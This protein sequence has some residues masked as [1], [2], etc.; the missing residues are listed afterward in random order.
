[1]IARAALSGRADLGSRDGSTVRACEAA[2]RESVRRVRWSDTGH[3]DLV[4][5]GEIVLADEPARCDSL[6]L[7]WR[8]GEALSATPPPMAPSQPRLVQALEQVIVADLLRTWRVGDVA[9]RLGT[10]TRRLQRQLQRSGSS[11][12]ELVHGVRIA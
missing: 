3:H 5:D 9:T 7:E 1:M 12:S 6:E 11:F 4:L 2:H 10:S 8:D